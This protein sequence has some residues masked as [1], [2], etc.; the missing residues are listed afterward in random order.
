MSSLSED[1][2]HVTHDCPLAYQSQ[3]EMLVSQYLHYWESGGEHVFNNEKEIWNKH[4]G[5][6][7]AV[8]SKGPVMPIMSY[9]LNNQGCSNACLLD[10]N[11][12]DPSLPIS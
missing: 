3:Y 8:F 10:S 7:I 9:V 2:E 4:R 12:F 1:M 6:L 5:K 11:I